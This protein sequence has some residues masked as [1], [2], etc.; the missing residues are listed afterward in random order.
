MDYKQIAKFSTI[1]LLGATINLMVLYLAVEFIR[2]PYIIGAILAY[3]IGITNNFFWNKFWTFKNKSKHYKEQYIKYFLISLSSLAINL[4]VLSI[5]V[6]LFGLWYMFS[7]AIA[8][9]MAGLNNY[10]WNKKLTFK[11]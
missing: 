11:D 5:L 1:G 7:Q 6:E 8:I 4:I 9:V 10:I 2:L 3:I